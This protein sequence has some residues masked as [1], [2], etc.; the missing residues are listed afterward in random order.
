MGLMLILSAS[1]YNAQI[2]LNWIK[3]QLV[4]RAEF[5][6]DMSAFLTST[7]GDSTGFI[8][9]YLFIIHH[10]NLP[11]HTLYDASLIYR[12]STSG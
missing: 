9:R 7:S 1:L 5:Y 11:G 8:D 4:K 2:T 12:F 6:A 3:P 10:L